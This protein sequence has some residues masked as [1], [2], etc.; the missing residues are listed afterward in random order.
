[1]ASDPVQG[2]ASADAGTVLAS[3]DAGAGEAMAA[4]TQASADTEAR[5]NRAATARARY[6]GAKRTRCT[7]PCP[8]LT[9]A[10]LTVD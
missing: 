9:S 3:A 10:D 2:P 6:P 5:E 8:D 7:G 4:T 1:M